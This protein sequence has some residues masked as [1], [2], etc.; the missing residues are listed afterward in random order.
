MATH[1]WFP[2]PVQR[3][4]SGMFALCHICVYFN[5]KFAVLDLKPFSVASTNIVLLGVNLPM[6]CMY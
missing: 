6:Y 2:T 3:L 5:V 1:L 4:G